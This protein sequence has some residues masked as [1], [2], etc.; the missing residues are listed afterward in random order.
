MSFEP[1]SDTEFGHGIDASFRPA[2]PVM[3]FRARCLAARAAWAMPA[4]GDQIAAG[5]AHAKAEGPHGG[6]TRHPGM[7]A[8]LGNPF[9]VGL[10]WPEKPLFSDLQNIP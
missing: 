3:S 8:A 4:I 6:P 5:A 1:S 2:P 7:L 9:R 10:K